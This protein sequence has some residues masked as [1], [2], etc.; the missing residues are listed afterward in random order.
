MPKEN[1]TNSVEN[2]IRK[3]LLKRIPPEENDKFML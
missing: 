3:A 2:I 1:I